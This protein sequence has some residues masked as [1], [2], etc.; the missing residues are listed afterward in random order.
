MYEHFLLEM[1]ILY[2]L[3][4]WGKLL[5]LAQRGLYFP[6][7]CGRRHQNPSKDAIMERLHRT[8]VKNG[9]LE[10]SSTD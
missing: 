10:V 2:S 6:Y 9:M 1:L 3:Y 8:I 4:A 5:L 7:S